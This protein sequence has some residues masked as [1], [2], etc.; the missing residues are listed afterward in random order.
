MI[1]INYLYIHFSF[2]A[3]I[4]ST[5]R[6]NHVGIVA[7]KKKEKKENGTSSSSNTKLRKRPHQKY[8]ASM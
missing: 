6:S 1:L 2:T 4:L 3:Q 5:G 7:L 8:V